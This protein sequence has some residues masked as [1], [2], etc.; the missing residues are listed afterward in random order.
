MYSF[1]YKAVGSDNKIVEGTLQS[2]SVVA[3]RETLNKQ[4]LRPI[5]IKPVSGK[6]SAFS[7]LSRTKIKSKDLVV[8][9]RQL[10]TM[11]N[12]GV[13]LPRSLSTLQSQTE[14]KK[15]KDV[16][17]KLNKSIEGGST[18]AEA[19]SNFPN[20]FSSVY[21]NMVRAGEAGGILDD[22]LEKLAIQQE[23]EATIKRKFKSAMTY[24]TVLIVITILVFIGLMT[25]VIP[26]LAKIITELSTENAQIPLLTRI[27]LSISDFMTTYWYALIGISSAAVYFL[28]K[29]LKTPTGGFKKDQLI[30]K[31]P[32]IKVVIT[33]IAVARFARTFAS[34]M[35]AGVGVLES[36]DITGKAIGN[37]VLEKELE[38]AAIDIA[39]G[40][41]LSASIS[42]SKVFPPIVPQMLAIGEETGKIDTILVKVAEF[43]EEE[44]DATLDSLGSIIEPIMIVVMGGMVGLIAASVMGPIT[45]L[46]NQI[47]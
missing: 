38:K 10:S 44:V 47:S 24:P 37:K 28:R 16:V 7:K 12:A 17:G 41:T 11:I 42:R 18:Y 32:I 33:K 8:F 35:G 22:I 2:S 3:A 21:I 19:L 20:I 46:T 27:M 25:F 40:K 9:T 43:Y 5:S 36:I 26:N 23:K 30:L 1:N 14:N 6:F 4:N 31:I 34:L 15:L 29:Y 39:T 13:P 45:N